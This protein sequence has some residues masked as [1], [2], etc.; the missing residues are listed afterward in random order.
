MSTPYR[1]YARLISQSLLPASALGIVFLATPAALGAQSVPPALESPA[2]QPPQTGPH[3]EKLVG[4]PK[5]H[6]PAPYDIDEHTGYKQIF[7]GKNVGRIKGV[8]S[9]LKAD[10]MFACTTPG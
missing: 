4:M 10:A 2:A 1:R 7:D 6:D 8:G 9:A 5:F 3:G